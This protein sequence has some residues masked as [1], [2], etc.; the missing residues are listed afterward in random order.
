MLKAIGSLL[1]VI[2]IDGPLSRSG[3]TRIRCRCP[4]RNEGPFKGVRAQSQP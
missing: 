4:E 2:D 1:S 3:L